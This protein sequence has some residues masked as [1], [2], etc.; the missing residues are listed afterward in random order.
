[1]IEK[2]KDVLVIGIDGMMGYFIEKFIDE[3]FLP[4][5]EELISNGFMA[6]AMPSPPCDTPTNWTT[7][8]TGA[9]TGRHGITS[10]YLH[11]PGEPL[12]LGMHIRSRGQL[13][14]YCRVQFLWSTVAE[15]G[16]PVLVINYPSGWGLNQP[17]IAMVSGTWYTPG[18][19][20]KVLAEGGVY[21]S[22]PKVNENKLIVCDKTSSHIDFKLVIK[23]SSTLANSIEIKGRIILS[24]SDNYN[25]LFIDDKSAGVGEW[26]D[27]IEVK[28]ET[29]Y[30]KLSALYRL[31]LLEA[32]EEVVRV[33]LSRIYTVQGWA[34]PEDLCRK[35]VSN[36]IYPAD[37]SEHVRL[38]RLG[39]V[40]DN[41][42]AYFEWSRLEALK[43][44]DVTSYLK[45]LRGW[46]LCY[47]HYHLLDGVNH[48]LSRIYEGSPLYNSEKAPIYWKFMREAYKLVDWFVGELIHKC[49]SQNTVVVVTSDHGVIPTWRNVSLVKPLVEAGLMNY[50][51]ENHKLKFD[52]KN[53]KVFPY[54]EPPY[55]WVN[56]EGRDPY[57]VVRRSEYEEV[58]DQII[59][60]L[61]SI[62]D[63]DTDERIIESAFRREEDPYLDGGNLADTI[64]D[65][66]YYLKQG[67]Q[68]FDGSVEALNCET[69]DPN[70][71]ER[72]VWTPNEVFGAHLYYKPG[73][74]VGGF[75]V[76]ATVIMNGPGIN[77]GVKSKCKIS[78]KDLVPTIAYL[79]GV[80]EPKGC[81]GRILE[82]A[83]DQ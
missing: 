14:K 43:L 2:P 47:L 26:T 77:K 63:P 73:T 17:N 71:T 22:K 65:V 40:V 64:G 48:F 60:V 55:I 59:E 52:E 4:V 28:C 57:G 32:G 16:M 44:V 38:A 19:P 36:Y 20:P 3:G 68:F 18:I 70:L 81:E 39:Y 67:Y 5:F 34:W 53:S 75:T 12:A 82:D 11:I 76:N 31:K 7:I 1:M 61:Y 49:A 23:A 46:V 21:S 72:Y 37:F 9:G 27:W 50:K 54:Y 10:F 8:A 6:E 80:A 45:S 83:L 13:A 79:L 33:E 56:L 35:L 29:D 69:V 66:T 58:R 42:E 30:G 24:K 62:R 78:L 51:P 15:S 25:L 74:E 41:V